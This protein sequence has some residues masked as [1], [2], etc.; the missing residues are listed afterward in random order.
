MGNQTRDSQ[1]AQTSWVLVRAVLELENKFLI[2]NSN[3]QRCFQANRS[4]K[5]YLLHFTT[6]DISGWSFIMG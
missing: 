5:P 4:P 3:F 6:T 1:V 2:G